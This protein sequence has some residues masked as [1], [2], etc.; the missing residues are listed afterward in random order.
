MN[1]ATLRR[2][3]QTDNQPVESGGIGT[4]S[5]SKNNGVDPQKLVDEYG[6]DTARLF[7][8]FAS[9]PTQTLEWADAGVDGAHRFL[10]RL[11]RQAYTHLQG[12]LIKA[13][14]GLHATLPPELKTLRGQLHQT[15]AKLP[16]SGTPP[17]LQYRHRRHNGTDGGLAKCQDSDAANRNLMQEALENIVLLLSPIVPHICHELWHELRPDTELLINLGRRRMA[18]LWY[19][20]KSN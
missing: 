11:W 19:K 2:I 9:P 1:R 20:T 18:L 13:D 17:Y 16:T 15:I 6:A 7:M 4:M 5:K 14:P 8:M 3:L 12:G 10:K